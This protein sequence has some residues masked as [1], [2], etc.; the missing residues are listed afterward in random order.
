MNKLELMKQFM[1]TFVGNGFN[2]I[3]KDKNRLH[4]HTIEIFQKTDDTCP[5]KEIPVGDY[6]LRLS[7]RDEN[8][9]ETSILCSWSEQL[10][11]NLL[12]HA[13]YAREAGY[14]A[15]TMIRSPLNQNNWLLI[16]GDKP[17]S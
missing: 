16:W 10:I 7:A 4:I 17:A 2:L 5:L 8:N 14:K 9:R 12:E 6:F 11:K 1:S 13:T 3:I 15:I